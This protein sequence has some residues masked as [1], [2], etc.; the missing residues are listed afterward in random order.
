MPKERKTLKF[1][2]QGTDWTT[3]TLKWYHIEKVQEMFKGESVDQMQAMSLKFVSALLTLLVDD[4]RSPDGSPI[5]PESVL[6]GVPS[7]LSGD[8]LETWQFNRKRQWISRQIDFEDTEEIMVTIFSN[9]SDSARREITKLRQEMMAADAGN[10]TIPDPGTLPSSLVPPPPVSP[11]TL[12]PGSEISS[13]LRERF[14]FPKPIKTDKP[15][16]PSEPSE[17]VGNTGLEEKSA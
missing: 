8:E 11:E 1:E 14:T 4:A 2:L 3:G 10:P 15:D 16:R 5:I 7:G 12:V 9:M 13:E 17:T 6:N